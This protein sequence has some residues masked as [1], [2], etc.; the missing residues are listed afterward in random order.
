MNKRNVST[1]C[2]KLLLLK[3][4]LTTDLTRKFAAFKPKQQYDN[5]STHKAFFQPCLSVHQL[6]FRLRNENQFRLIQHVFVTNH[7]THTTKRDEHFNEIQANIS[8]PD[9][10]FWF[11]CSEL[12]FMV[13][14]SHSFQ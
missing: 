2:K 8:P 10:L 14:C 7:F 11:E 3:R 12:S 13:A 1:N 9:D 5:L 4:M 6:K